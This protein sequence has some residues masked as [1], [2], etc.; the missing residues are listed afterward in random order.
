MINSLVI[1]LHIL[2]I[3]ILHIIVNFDKHY[4]A[5]KPLARQNGYKN[6]IVI[7][8]YLLINSMFLTDINSVP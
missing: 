4:V 6:K 2:Y 3:Y 1:S 7:N 5:G 8:A